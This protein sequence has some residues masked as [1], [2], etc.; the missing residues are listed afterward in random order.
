MAQW[1]RI[2][3]PELL[4]NKL[5]AEGIAALAN[6]ASMTRLI[7]TRDSRSLSDGGASCSSPAGIAS[8]PS[9]VLRGG[10]VGARGS[11]SRDGST[12]NPS[13]MLWSQSAP[14]PPSLP[15]QGQRL[16]E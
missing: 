11:G 12:A 14:P 3:S 5:T 8:M 16:R 7:S 13:A 2:A 1:K 6:L 9:C 4:P 10:H 15:R